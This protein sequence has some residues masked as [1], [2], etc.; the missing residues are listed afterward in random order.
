MR[1]EL[2]YLRIVGVKSIKDRT[3]KET[4]WLGDG[5]RKPRRNG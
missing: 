3:L 2:N 4:Q 5:Q 1:S